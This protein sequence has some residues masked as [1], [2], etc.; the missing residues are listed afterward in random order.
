MSTSPSRST[1]P[2][3]SESESCNF[4]TFARAGTAGAGGRIVMAIMGVCVCLNKIRVDVE[5]PQPRLGND[6]EIS[7]ETPTFL[8]PPSPCP[9][10]VLGE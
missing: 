7:T 10:L 2:S 8:L 4:A 3:E 6:L 1:P 5:E 9:L